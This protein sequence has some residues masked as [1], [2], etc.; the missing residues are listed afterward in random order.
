LVGR[1]ALSE[2]ITQ[3][4]EDLRKRGAAAAEYVPVD[5][6]DGDAVAELV[7]GIVA[8][9]GGLDGVLHSAGVLRDGLLV[10]KTDADLRAVFAPKVEGVVALD[11]ATRSLRL[12]CFVVFS[13]TSAV[14]GNLGQADYAAAN[15]LLDAYARHRVAQVVAGRRWGRTV[16]VNWPLWAEGGM[17]VTELTKQ[18]LLR[19]AA[20]QPLNTDKGLRALRCALA[21]GESQILVLNGE[22]ERIRKTM[23][24][25]PVTRVEEPAEVSEFHDEKVL[26]SEIEKALVVLV[27]DFM[28]VIGHDEID[29]E[30]EFS[31]L[32]FDSISLLA[33]GN[34][35]H[36]RFGVELSPTVFFE[37]PTFRALTEYL[38]ENYRPHLIERLAEAPLIA[39]EESFALHAV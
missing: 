36:Q 24:S 21:S 7:V 6:S 33:L 39:A 9:Y 19:S 1:S 38:A 25:T 16:C 20:M 14:Y 22:A 5:V 4:M 31:E 34:K 32:G 12:E 2:A 8:R 15:G 29:T 30:T 35:L 23:L 11:E 3:Q 27:K 37:Y 13:S 18:R 26:K 10:N 28:K 17:Q